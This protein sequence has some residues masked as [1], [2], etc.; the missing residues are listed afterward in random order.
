LLKVVKKSGEGPSQATMDQSWFKLHFIADCA[1]KILQTEVSGGDPG[2]AETSKMLAEAGLC[3]A[4]DRATL[5]ALAGV[6]T[7]AQAMGETL[8]ARLQRAGLSFRVLT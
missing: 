1:G 6:L 5:P 4:Q 7:P 8:L 2:Y 3:L